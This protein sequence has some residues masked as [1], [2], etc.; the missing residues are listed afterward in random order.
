MGGDHDLM[1]PVSHHGATGITPLEAKNRQRLY[2][3]MEDC[4][5]NSYDR[6]WWHYTMKHEP[7]PNTYFDFPITWPSR[8]KELPKASHPFYEGIGYQ[9]T[10]TSHTYRKEV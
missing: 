5:F 3:I 4:G 6:E 9:R 10:T 2:C 7:Y 1:D 8:S